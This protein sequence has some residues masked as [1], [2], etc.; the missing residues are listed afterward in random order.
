MISSPSRPPRVALAL[1]GSAELATAKTCP[2]GSTPTGWTDLTADAGAPSSTPATVRIQAA[3]LRQAQTMTRQLRL[4]EAEAGRDPHAL[5]VLVDL[6]FLIASE[7]R[8]ARAELS[9]GNSG[10]HHPDRSATIRYVGTPSGLAGLISDIRAA[11]VADGVTLIPLVTS[12]TH[13]EMVTQ[14]VVPLLIPR[15]ASK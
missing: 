8:S 1:S 13:T 2:P 5:I 14:Q 12:G 11:S 3:D 15:E 9:A 6:E 7:A 10:L 4:R